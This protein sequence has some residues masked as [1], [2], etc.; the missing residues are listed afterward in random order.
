MLGA[1]AV[2]VKDCCML[3]K[4]VRD[5]YEFFSVTIPYRKQHIHH[6]EYGILLFPPIILECFFNLYRTQ[7]SIGSMA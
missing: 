6:T 1:G 2:V 7:A 3:S 4:V 5:L